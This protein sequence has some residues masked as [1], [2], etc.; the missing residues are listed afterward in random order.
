MHCDLA[1]RN[2]LIAEGFVLKIS[3]FGMARDISGKEY[4]RKS[5]KVC[6]ND[7]TN[8]F[9]SACTILTGHIITGTG[10]REMDS[11]RGLGRTLVYIQ[12]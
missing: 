9:S 3:D 8:I 4:Y 7:P 1:A 5:P 2:I 11:S 12:K 10:T 6:P